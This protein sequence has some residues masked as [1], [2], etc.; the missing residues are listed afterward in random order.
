MSTSEQS[1]VLDR[2]CWTS[3][4]G[5]EVV[6]VDSPGAVN[7]GQAERPCWIPRSISSSRAR[8]PAGAVSRQLQLRVLN[9]LGLALARLGSALAGAATPTQEPRAIAVV[10]SVFVIRTA[11]LGFD[12]STQSS[13]IDPVVSRWPPHVAPEQRSVQDLPDASQRRRRLHSRPSG[14]T[15]RFSDLISHASFSSPSI[16]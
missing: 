7:V 15:L 5:F 8:L 10:I 1:G 3:L 13:F 12:I 9:G 6:A 11:G 14:Q 4:V 2:P 16:S